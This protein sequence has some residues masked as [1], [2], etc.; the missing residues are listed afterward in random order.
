QIADLPLS[1]N[2][3][4]DVELPARTWER[5][6]YVLDEFPIVGTVVGSCSSR[7]MKD[8][9]ATHPIAFNF[10]REETIGG[11]ETVKVVTSRL[12]E[13]KPLGIELIGAAHMGCWLTRTPLIREIGMTVGIDGM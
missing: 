4:D 7:R 10:V 1:L 8:T 12:V 6:T 5:L 2:V 3:E 13:E 11:V 9:E